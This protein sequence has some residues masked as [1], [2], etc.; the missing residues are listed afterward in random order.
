[1]S[2]LVQN[3]GLGSE[4]HSYGR[5]Y[6][7]NNSRDIWPNPFFR[8]PHIHFSNLKCNPVN[9][10]TLTSSDNNPEVFDGNVWTINIMNRKYGPFSHNA[11]NCK[12]D[13][14]LFEDSADS[15]RSI[16]LSWKRDPLPTSC[17]YPSSLRNRGECIEKL[18][19]LYIGELTRDHM[20]PT[21]LT[22]RSAD[23][24][25]VFTMNESFSVHI[26]SESAVGMDYLIS[27][28]FNKLEE[29]QFLILFYSEE[30]KDK[31][32]KNFKLKANSWNDVKLTWV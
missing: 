5:R 2:H 16:P 28:P 26:V 14:R 24:L 1:M 31:Q 25:L 18:P 32:G 9:G 8:R 21:I 30:Y 10:I 27:I 20:R 15:G 6:N 29:Y 17:N 3:V 19:W 4:R 23:M 11:S 22:N 12:M 13:M 7:C